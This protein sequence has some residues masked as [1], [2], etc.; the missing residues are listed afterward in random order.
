MSLYFDSTN[1][2]KLTETLPDRLHRTSLPADRP[3]L[4]VTDHFITP[5]VRPGVEDDGVLLA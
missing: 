4:P 1:V 5:T 2:F 3:S